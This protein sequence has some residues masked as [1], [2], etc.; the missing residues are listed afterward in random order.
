[1][2]KKPVLL[3]TPY[4]N[5][6]CIYSQ[7]SSP[8]AGAISPVSGR[9]RQ[10]ARHSALSYRSYASVHEPPRSSD[11]SDDF[12]WPRLA[13][14]G[15]IPSPYQ[16]F[17]LKRNAPYTKQ[18]YYRLVKIYHPDRTSLDQGSSHIASLPGAVKMERYRLIVAAHE[19]LSDPTKRRAYDKT[20][21]GWNGRPE[22]EPPRHY[23]TSHGEAKWSGFDTNDS[24][25]RNATW[26]DW[27]KW[28]QRQSGKKQSP[29]YTSNGGFL[30]LIVSVVFL[31]AFGQSL[32]VEDYG[33]LFRRQ[34]EQVHD[35]ASKYMRQRRVETQDFKNR[36]ARLQS[37]LRTR[38]PHGYG[39]DDPREASY[40]K[41][42]PE[43]EACISD[44]VHQQGQQS[45][46]SQPKS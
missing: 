32:R 36:D 45:V 33:S 4:A 3:L 24:P 46:R 30:T 17:Q 42:L 40:Q 22:N 19:I 1:M 27:E 16:I 20:G 35:D 44:V 12:E 15:Q 10:D 37:F 8:S 41:L 29:V 2:L 26:E 11:A 38:D 25:F 5:L 39:I 23:W 6:Q 18:R 31:G 7:T 13:H 34:V 28:Y 14:S 43:P 9:H 21:A